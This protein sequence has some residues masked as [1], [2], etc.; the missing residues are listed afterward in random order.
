MAEQSDYIIIY[1]ARGKK[2]EWK[3]VKSALKE[4]GITGI[5][6][7][8]WDEDPTMSI[9]PLDPRDFGE[10]GR[11]DRKIYTIWVKKEDADLASEIVLRNCPD[12]VPYDRRNTASHSDA[13]PDDDEK[14]DFLQ[15]WKKH[16]IFVIFGVVVL[17]IVL[18]EILTREPYQ[19]DS[20]GRIY[21]YDSASLSNIYEFDAYATE[22][23]YAVFKAALSTHKVERIYVDINESSNSASMYYKRVDDEVLYRTINPQT[24]GF[25]EQILEADILI[26]PRAD[27]FNFEN[28]MGIRPKLAVGGLTAL[29]FI[30]GGFVLL[31]VFFVSMMRVAR[32]G[33]AGP[34]TETAGE[35]F[36]KDEVHPEKHKTFN[37][38]GGL[39]PLKEDLKVVVDFLKSPERYHEAGAD[40]PKGLLLVGPPGTG[41]T[42]IAQ[43]MADEAGV[44]FLYA[45]ASDFVEKYVGTGAARVRELFRKARK[46]TPCIIFID[47]VDTLCTKRDGEMNAEDRKSLTAL[48][49]EM[50][51][52]KKDDNILVIGATN[53]VEDIDEAA[54]RPG[55]F[56]EIYAVP[57]PETIEERLEVIDIYMKNKKFAEDFDR[58]SF[59]REMMGRSP[60][61]IKDV[62]NEAAIISVQKGLDAINKECVEIAFYKRLMHGHQKDHN[63]TD[64]D[65]LRMIAYH[66][67]GHTLVARLTGSK[68]TKVTIMPSTSG[69][70]GVTFVA[71][72]EK[73]LFTKA[74]ME[75][76]VME[77]YAGKVAEYLAGDRNWDNTSQGCSNDIEKATEILKN[78]VDAYGMS[79]NALV[80]MRILSRE[81]SEKSSSYI[82]RLSEQLRDRTVRLMEENFHLLQKLAE[83]LLVRDTLYEDEINT[84]LGLEA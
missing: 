40:L 56:T 30:I 80:N 83:E 36:E 78:M 8:A 42:L 77:L 74:M 55:R 3:Q 63:E 5:R 25:R 44:G 14:Q 28:P 53:R 27:L 60:A 67:A 73:K 15:Y 35:K 47:E 34:Q 48:L 41:K 33:F 54:L 50:D 23:S 43:V 81:T 38:I 37:D 52:F 45:N 71:P 59:A 58:M 20:E 72:Q 16:I 22:V 2:A 11:I 82:V 64:P 21:N 31:G 62:L 26:Y 13:P 65:D 57:I 10:K 69:A 32:K 7:N 19:P 39:K 18:A 17:I 6:S 79:D 84:L 70:G 1:E 46:E 76:K 61:E 75:H 4:A 66:E 29:P 51:G 68:V 12:Y 49:T 9:Y 24:E